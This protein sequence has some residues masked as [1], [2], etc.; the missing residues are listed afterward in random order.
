[1]PF[2]FTVS[3]ANYTSVSQLITKLQQS[4]RPIQIDSFDLTGGSS[5]MTLTVNAH[6]YYQPA[7]SVSIT[8]KVIK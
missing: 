7:K 1:M 8:K 4:T 5:N 6:T 2:S 3:N